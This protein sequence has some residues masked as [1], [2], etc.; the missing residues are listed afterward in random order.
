MLTQSDMVA[1]LFP[2]ALEKPPMGSPFDIRA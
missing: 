1:A 2:V